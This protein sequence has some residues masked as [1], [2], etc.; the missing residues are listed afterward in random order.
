VAYLCF[1][2]TSFFLKT[3][4]HSEVYA[5]FFAA[6]CY[7]GTTISSLTHKQSAILNDHHPARAA[8]YREA[9]AR[10]RQ[11][12]T[13]ATLPDLRAALL[14]LAECYE[15]LAIHTNPKFSLTLP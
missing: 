14:E 8:Q 11:L 6:L 10:I 9:A 4:L 3:A 12:A 7:A 15:R 5:I 2:I 13:S 1:S